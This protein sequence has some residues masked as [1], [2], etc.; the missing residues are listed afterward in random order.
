MVTAAQQYHN[1]LSFR[2]GYKHQFGPGNGLLL[3]SVFH[4]QLSFKVATDNFS[5]L[6]FATAVQT[7]IP[8]GKNTGS[9]PFSLE[10]QMTTTQDPF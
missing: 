8:L 2:A 9:L 10:S 5:Q 4:L 7:I 6:V 1:K 3:C